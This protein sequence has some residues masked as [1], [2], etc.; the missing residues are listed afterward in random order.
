MKGIILRFTLC[1][2]LLALCLGCHYA[3]PRSEVVPSLTSR[4]PILLLGVNAPGLAGNWKMAGPDLEPVTTTPSDTN[5]PIIF[6]TGYNTN[7]DPIY[8]PLLP[9]N[10]HEGVQY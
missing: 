9:P 10:Y 3:E 6:R 8:I 4:L 7:L 5:T 1:A 2:V